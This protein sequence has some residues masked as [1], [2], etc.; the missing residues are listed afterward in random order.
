MQRA[1][2]LGLQRQRQLAHLIEEQR[3]ALRRLHAAGTLAAGTAEGTARMAEQLALGQRFRQRRAIDLHQRPCVPAR[4]PVQPACKQLLA[5]T[6]LA[7]QQHRQVALGDDAA[8]VQQRAQGLAMGDDLEVV[9]GRHRQ[10]RGVLVLARQ[11]HAALAQ[12]LVLALQPRHAHR[13]LDLAR[14]ARQRRAR[15]GIEA[16]RPQPVERQRAPGPTLLLQPHAHAVV[17]GQRLAFARG[18]ESVVRV[19]QAAVVLEGHRPGRRHDG[20]QPRLL[21]QA[22]AAAE[23]VAHQPRRRQRPQRRGLVVGFQRQQRHGVAA[24][25]GLH[26]RGQLLQAFGRRLRCQQQGQQRAFDQ[27]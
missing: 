9:V 17:H 27:G 5:D 11:A 13:Q 15:R 14:H 18:N 26:R 3:A 23:R 1:Q 8:F 10:R 20:R 21:G 22:E 24:E 4:Q 19:G 7:Q 12:R 2:Q 6:R 16:P 25:A